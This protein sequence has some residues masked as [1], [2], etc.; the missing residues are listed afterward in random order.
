V[1]LII[2]K[3]MILILAVF[4]LVLSVVN[5][6]FVLNAVYHRGEIVEEASLHTSRSPIVGSHI[7]PTKDFES[8]FV[9]FTIVEANT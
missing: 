2:S 3:R 9:E 1:V 4:L 5:T 7:A 6:L 8:G